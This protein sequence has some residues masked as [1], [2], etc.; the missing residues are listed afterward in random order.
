[1]NLDLWCTIYIFDYILRIRF[2]WT[3]SRA[4]RCGPPWRRELWAKS[5]LNFS[6]NSDWLEAEAASLPWWQTC[7]RQLQVH[8]GLHCKFQRFF[9][10]NKNHEPAT[11]Q[12]G[13][14]CKFQWHIIR[15]FNAQKN[16]PTRINSFMTIYFSKR[17]LR[18]SVG[19]N[20]I[21]SLSLFPMTTKRQ[22]ELF[23]AREAEPV[24]EER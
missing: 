21:N 23:D 10:A 1:V 24:D 14:H 15:L 13:L 6:R 2:G 8:S 9:K 4:Q 7:P 11:F 5:N 3:S 20:L 17:F 16:C 19:T 12:P 22:W 18:T